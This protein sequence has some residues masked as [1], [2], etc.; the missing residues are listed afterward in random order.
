LKFFIFAAF[1][2]LSGAMV[3]CTD[4]QDEIDALDLRV[5]RL[6]E[7]V[8]TMNSNI[9]ALR[10]IV[11]A[12]EDGDY[13]TGVRETT[14]GY[15]INFAKAGPVLILD[16][17]DGLDGKD[18]EMPDIDVVQGTDGNYYWVI[19]GEFVTHNG[20]RIR[21]NGK[22]GKDGKD[23]ISPQVRINPTTSEWEVSY[24]GG[25]TWTPTGTSAKGKDGVDGNQVVLK[26]TFETSSEG[27]F[28]IVTTNTG[29]F[30]VPCK[31]NK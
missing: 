31:V 13:I 19:D 14:D 5:K 1:V 29:Q 16:G 27:E 6:E 2:A 4:Y 17:V 9:E 24:D 28:M 21:V 23:A 20:N 7:L 12:M 22:D 8:S 10:I 3:S 26:V 11:D 25:N 30:K 18:A 15:V